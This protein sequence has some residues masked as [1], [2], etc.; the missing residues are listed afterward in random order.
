MTDAS[1]EHSACIQPETGAAQ[2]Q[3]ALAPADLDYISPL[4]LLLN[5]IKSSCS[6]IPVNKN[7]IFL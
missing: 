6:S 4:G 2:D 5:F 7:Q 3:Q 1:F